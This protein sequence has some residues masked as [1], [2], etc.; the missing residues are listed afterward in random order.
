MSHVKMPREAALVAP[1]SGAFFIVTPM[2]SIW[3][4]CKS[5]SMAM[6]SSN[7]S[8][9]SLSKR[10]RVFPAVSPRMGSAK[11]ARQRKV[12]H[13]GRNGENFDRMR[14]RSTPFHDKKENSTVTYFISKV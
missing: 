5:M 2:S 13:R 4:D 9:M 11:S 10:T 3:G 6:P 7:I 8:T 14:M 12:R 1:F